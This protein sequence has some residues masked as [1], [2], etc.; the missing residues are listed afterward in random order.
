MYPLLV[1]IWSFLLFDSFLPESNYDQTPQKNLLPQWFPWSIKMHSLTECLNMPLLTLHALHC[2]DRNLI[3]YLPLASEP[4]VMCRSSWGSWSP[5]RLAARCYRSS[6]VLL[7][8][9]ISSSIICCRSST[10]VRD[11]LIK[12]AASGLVLFLGWLWTWL[13]LQRP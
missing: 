12:K 13:D 5:S 1:L 11:N 6:T 2:C 4:L 8:S 7:W 3:G 10:K 9:V